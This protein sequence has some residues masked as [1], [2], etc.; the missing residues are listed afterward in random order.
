LS[1]LQPQFLFLRFHKVAQLFEI[2]SPPATKFCRAGYLSVGGHELD[3][4]LVE[5]ENCFGVT[6]LSSLRCH[7]LDAPF[8]SDG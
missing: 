2:E 1:A 4:P 6:N 5:A 8:G 7:S 3:V